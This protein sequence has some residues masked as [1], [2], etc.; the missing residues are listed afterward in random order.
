MCHKKL[1]WWLFAGIHGLLIFVD[2]FMLRENKCPLCMNDEHAALI[3]SQMAYSMS[4]YYTGW[5][6]C[7]AVGLLLWGKCWWFSHK[8]VIKILIRL[9][10][11]KESNNYAHE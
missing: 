8:T 11:L 2:Y 1:F 6:V 5:M 10:C 7:K 3:N 9:L 4:L